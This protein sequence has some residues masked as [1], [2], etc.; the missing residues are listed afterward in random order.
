MNLRKRNCYV[1]FI[2]S[3]TLT[4]FFPILFPSIKLLFFI[5]YLVVLFYKQP[6]V[7]CLWGAFL[8][9]LII[10]LLSSQT[11]VGLW[12]LTYTATTY[13]LYKQRLNFFG[14]KQS[15]LPIMTF[16]FSLVLTGIHWILL[17]IFENAF[18][19]SFKSITTDL[20][21]MPFLDGIYSYFA[22]VLP[23]VLIQPQPRRGSDYFAN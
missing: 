11:R 20:L 13:L 17:L 19:I 6:Y 16:L 14:D 2:I 12:T 8:C 5:P 23:W 7:K 10:D 9:G 21:F 18:S 3:L 4:L 15:T 1:M 22:F